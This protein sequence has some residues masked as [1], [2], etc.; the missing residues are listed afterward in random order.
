MIK[1]DVVKKKA[2]QGHSSSV[3]QSDSN[4]MK[5]VKNSRNFFGSPSNKKSLMTEMEAKMFAKENK[6]R[7]QLIKVYGIEKDP[8]DSSKHSSFS[9]SMMTKVSPKRTKIEDYNSKSTKGLQAVDFLPK[10]N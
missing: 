6:D 10:K 9:K 5:S 3:V 8:K 1:Q 4:L 7:D 2:K